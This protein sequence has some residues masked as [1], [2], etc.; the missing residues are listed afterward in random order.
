MEMNVRDNWHRLSADTQRWFTENPGCVILPRTLVA[1][2]YEETG[3]DTDY[4]RH[5]QISLSQED[6]GFIQAQA[7]P[8]PP[9]GPEHRFFEATRP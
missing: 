1:T 5:G 3:L 2:I 8:S 6:R 4:D 9:T 7:H